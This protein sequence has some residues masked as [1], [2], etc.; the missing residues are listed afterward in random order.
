M[1]EI[2]FNKVKIN[3]NITEA[4]SRQ[5]LNSGDSVNTLFGKVKKWLSDLKA[6]AF[7]G[8]YNDLSDKP[9]SLPANGGNADTVNNHYVNSDVPTDAVFTD[10][11]RGIQDNLVSDST[12]DSLSA[13]QG[14]ILNE[15]IT[16]HTSN[17]NIHVTTD[18]KLKWNG[19]SQEIKQNSKKISVCNINLENLCDVVLGKSHT[20]QTDT[21][22]A[23]SK[24]VPVGARLAG[25][26][27]IG[28]RTICFNQLFDPSFIT[29]PTTKNGITVTN[30]GGVY[31][32]EGTVENTPTYF[33]INYT[34]NSYLHLGHKY[35]CRHNSD[36]G[37]LWVL[38][39]GQDINNNRH[40]Y[41][42][43]DKNSFFT[44]NSDLSISYARIYCSN[45]IGT[46]ISE[47]I[48][49]MLFDLTKMFGAGNEPETVEEFEAM[50]PD[51][52]YP[53]SEGELM[54][55]PVTALHSTIDGTTVERTQIPNEII[56]LEGYGDGI[57][58]AC[59]NYVDFE[60]KT[61]HKCVGAVDL[62]ALNWNKYT[63]QGSDHTFKAPLTDLSSD[64]N[65]NNGICIKYDVGGNVGITDGSN[66]G[67]WLRNNTKEIYLSDS[68]YTDV[69][70]FKAA[71]SGVTLYYGL[72]A[73]VNT[74]ISDLFTSDFNILD[75]IPG[76]QLTFENEN[77]IAVQNEVEYIVDLLEWIEVV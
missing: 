7:S 27:K 47:T 42:G 41:G 46:A 8:S 60:A 49:P 77:K 10:T 45:N 6:V 11:W 30:N 76:G 53:Y 36:S 67:I 54:A 2:N 40:N 25:V 28:G 65:N 19:Y 52:Y 61:Y 35:L 58:A 57:N 59:C 24:P 17:G 16:E 4:T 75:V 32:V 50:F 31:T 73:P 33:N 3:V 44:V 74:D 14:K 51:A 13:N 5:D 71:V 37:N 62:G 64:I 1:A 23:Y 66:K 69:E 55:S 56:A 15:K 63:V 43:L 38:I 72:E 12:T 39:F 21:T 70:A 20:F 34:E 18:N 48:T 26:K 68:T 9:A 22:A 29:A